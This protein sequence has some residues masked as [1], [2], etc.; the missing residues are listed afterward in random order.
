MRDMLVKLYELPDAAAHR[1]R[2]AAQ[3][4]VL[5]HAMAYELTPVRAWVREHFS[6]GWAD[7]VHACF[8]RQPVSCVLALEPGEAMAGTGTG[9]GA[10]AEARVGLKRIV[11]F[12]A[13]E[14]TTRG[15]FGPMGTLERARGKGVGAAVCLEALWA[16]RSM[17]YGYAIIG[18]V[19]PAAFY[20]KVC[21][22][23]LIEDS[24]PGVYAD[25]LDRASP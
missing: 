19:G 14:A 21:G 20:T 22:A 12:A 9:A 18:G 11:G 24:S 15:F 1:G 6:D 10:G 23:R 5:R 13:Y 17:G 7:E 25:M 16:M 2:M 3:G 4:L 8:S